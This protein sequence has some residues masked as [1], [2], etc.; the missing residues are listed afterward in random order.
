MTDLTPPTLVTTLPELTEMLGDLLAEPSVAVDTESNSLYAYHERVCLVQLSIP[1]RDYIVDP[2]TGL[3]ISPLGGLFADP[4]IEKVF[5]AAE[6]DVGWLK[7]ELEC[8]FANLFDTMWAARILGWPKVGLG[9]VLWETFQVDVN[10]KFQRYNWGKRP[11]DPE[12]ITYARLDTHYLLSL[13]DVEAKELEKMGRTEEAEEVFAELAQTSAA[14]PPFGPHGFWRMKAL[15]ELEGRE[16]AVL[17]ELYLWRDQVARQRN[18]PPFRILGKRTLAALARAR[19]R[20]LE[21]LTQVPGLKNHHVRRYGEA[22]LEAISRGE[23]GPIPKSSPRTSREEAARARYRALR[24]WRRD[25]A[26]Q[27][28]VDSDVVVSN[29]VLWALAEQQP[30]T[31]DDLERIEGLGPWKRETYGE[32][33]LRVLRRAT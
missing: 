32:D 5:H 20:R 7:R 22:I 9:D 27:R 1:G 29:S 16:R 21:D 6:Q 12:A 31:M 4:T 18:R 24:S 23:S 11:L 3:D 2:L 17:W 15:Q 10:K 33:L 30:D 13:R 8:A 25:M 26:R 14:T 19:P 28:Q